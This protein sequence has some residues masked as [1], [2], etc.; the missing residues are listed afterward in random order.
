M[1][2]FGKFTIKKF[3]LEGHPIYKEYGLYYDK[4]GALWQD[5]VKK[6]P[7]A[8]YAVVQNDG[9]IISWQE[10]ASQS[11]IDSIDIWGFTKKE[12]KKR[13]E[14]THFDGKKF[15]TPK[16]EITLE[17]RVITLEERIKALEERLDGYENTGRRD[18]TNDCSRCSN[19]SR[20]L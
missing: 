2:N 10:D 9:Q 11:Q 7:H 4:D 16:P 13:Q 17:E 18:G 15:Y 6:Y 5:L 14:H 12:V 1:Y 20:A 3:P 8:I 19:C